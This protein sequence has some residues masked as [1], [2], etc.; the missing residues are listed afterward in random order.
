MK[1]KLILTI[2]PGSTSTKIGIFEDN[3]CIFEETV[4]HST[5]QIEEYSQI[6]DQYSFR[7]EEIIETLEKNKFDIKKL[8][9]V[10]GRGGLIKPI[11]GG[12]YHI[13]QAMIEDARAGVQGHHASN[14]G[15]V[16]AYSIGWELGIPAFI[17]DPPS[18]NDLEPLARV[19]GNKHIDRA[20]LLHALN[21]FATARKYADSINKKF[22]ELNLI[23]AHMG[24]GITVAALRSGKAINVNNGLDE[25]PFTPER[26]G[27]LPLFPFM[28]M[29]LSGKYTEDELKKMIVG[30]GGLN[31]YFNTNKA[32]DVEN[33]IN[34]GSK[35]YKHVY[36]AMA[37]QIAQEIGARATNLNGKVDA[38]ILTGGVAHSKM[39]TGWISERT[40][41]IAD[42]EIFPG[43]AELEALASGALRVLRNEEPAKHYKTNIKKVGI[44]YWDN[45]E[46]YVSAINII[47]DVFRKN[48]YVFRKEDENIKIKYINCKQNEEKVMPAIEKFK[49]DEVDLIFAIGSPISLRLGQLL[50]NDNIPVIFTGIYSPAVIS[51]FNK[52]YNL[53]YYATCYAAGTDEHLDNTIFK[54]DPE[55]DKIGIIYTRGEVQ[56]EIQLDEFRDYC[57]R[58]KIKAFTYDIQDDEGYREAK[59]YFA[60]NK[61]KWIY[62]TTSTVVN[63]ANNETLKIIT[64]NFR[65]V[66]ILEDTVSEGCLI[67]NV[68]P[69]KD[70]C[71]EAVELALKI[72]DKEAIPK[73]VIIPKKTKSVAN[74][75]TA[76]KLN[77]LDEISAFPDVKFIE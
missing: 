56:S 45:L 76:E 61:I 38:I 39:L 8:D 58:R 52:E 59:K 48:G 40:K 18:V 43:E 32:T 9:A 42:V 23:V 31:S 28:K 20:S 7:K 17:V 16:I 33:M 77:M 57:D 24:G 14:L 27:Q 4:R 13:D 49:A 19:S 71:K 22:Q 21:I 29:C 5:K 47:E 60:K 10:S 36:E 34:A 67:A 30:K 37:Y 73:R 11:P 35:K 46:V 41:F 15:C 64:D 66:S 70:V 26:S 55:T 51:D 3:K 69:W 53:N 75:K 65:T 68:I 54:I 63:S 1:K 50:K 2:N 62:F 25:G 6:W 72:F 12:T 44:L 74:K